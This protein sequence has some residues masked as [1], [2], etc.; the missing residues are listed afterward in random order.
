MASELIRKVKRSRELE[1]AFGEGQSLDESEYDEILE[2][3]Q[4]KEDLEAI[5]RAE[6]EL[7]L[8]RVCIDRWCVIVVSEDF[9]SATIPAALR[10][11]A[12]A[13]QKGGE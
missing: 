13:I 11:A 9:S 5:A 10:A 3:L 6:D 12:E 4:A 7:T 1:S 2:A 8:T